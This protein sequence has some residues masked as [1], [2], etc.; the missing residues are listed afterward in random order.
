[1]F[2]VDTLYEGSELH[3]LTEHGVKGVDVLLLSH[4]GS[5]PAVSLMYVDKSS[6]RILS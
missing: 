2:Y 1:M 3:E 5:V 4:R 6:P